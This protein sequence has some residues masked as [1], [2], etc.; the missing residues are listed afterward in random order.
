[1]KTG[2]AKDDDADTQRGTARHEHFSA[3]GKSRE[4]IAPSRP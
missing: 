3:Q 2:V 1:V 4:V